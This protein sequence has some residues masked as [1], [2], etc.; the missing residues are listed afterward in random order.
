MSTTNPAL[1]SSTSVA[2]ASAA[3]GEPTPHESAKPS[4]VAPV[5]P[6][7][8]VNVND[9]NNNN[10]HNPRTRILAV[11]ASAGR[12]CGV[13]MG[14]PPDGTTLSARDAERLTSALSDLMADLCAAA[15]SLPLELN[16]VRSIR[17]KMALNARKYPVEHCK[18]KAG[19][20]TKYSHLTGVTTDN[21]S[22]ADFGKNNDNGDNNSNDTTDGGGG[23]GAVVVQSVSVSV[24]LDDFAHHHLVELSHDIG[25]FAEERLWA[26]YHTPRNLILAL[27]GEAGELAELLQWNGDGDNSDNSDNNKSNTT[28]TL[29]LE[30]TTLDKLSQELADVSIY[31]IRLATVCGVVDDLK[32]SLVERATVA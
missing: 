18:G 2:T 17:A 13:G 8:N 19:K 6:A 14:L 11:G 5:V 24:S 10:N 1:R 21:Q 27:L 26:K 20:Y 25:V 22:T 32:Q 3:T 15:S 29:A 4:Q 16:W 31:A 9:N 28:N 23:G 12:L 30:A 7:V